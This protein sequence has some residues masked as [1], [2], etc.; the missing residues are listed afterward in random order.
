VDAIS[1]EGSIEGTGE[2]REKNCTGKGCEEGEEGCGL[3]ELLVL[4]FELNMTGLTY[5][6]HNSGET[7]AP[8]RAYS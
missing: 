8:S 2:C 6:R 3:V 5:R 7:A 4:W 1:F